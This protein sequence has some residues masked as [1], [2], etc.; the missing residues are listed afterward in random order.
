[1][2]ATRTAATGSAGEH[3]NDKRQDY[4]N[5]DDHRH[6][7]Q[8]HRGARRDRADQKLNDGI[9]NPCGSRHSERVADERE[10]DSCRTFRIVRLSYGIPPPLF[11]VL[12]RVGVELRLAN[13]SADFAGSRVLLRT[14]QHEPRVRI[15]DFGARQQHADVLR[16]RVLTAD[17][18]ARRR[19]AA[20]HVPPDADQL[21]GSRGAGLTISD[22]QFHTR[23]DDV[24]EADR[25]WMQAV[26]PWDTRLHIVALTRASSPAR[27]CDR[28]EK[29][30]LLKCFDLMW[31]PVIECEHAAGA[32]TE[33]P[34]RG[35]Q[36]DMARQHVN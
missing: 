26:D 25:R 14:Q 27:P 17:L 4:D 23:S 32:K 6:R 13:L 28:Q 16:F 11:R 22:D 30:A 24:N 7:T 3:Q 29:R 33:C 12:C 9:E 1:M 36:L 19:S 10:K 20:T 34:S 31:N 21:S 35:L 2:W 18:N 5:R 15:A 8:C